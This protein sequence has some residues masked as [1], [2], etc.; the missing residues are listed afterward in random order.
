MVDDW[1]IRINFFFSKRKKF[2]V[3]KCE[4]EIPKNLLVSYGVW[5]LF[6]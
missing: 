1:K 2:L 3:V 5:K 6:R 4:V